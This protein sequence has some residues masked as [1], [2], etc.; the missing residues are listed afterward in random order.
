MHYIQKTKEKKYKIQNNI[1]EYLNFELKVD[2]LLLYEH[3][4]NCVLSSLSKIYCNIITS[5]LS[6]LWIKCPLTIFY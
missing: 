5:I 1:F 2:T 4:E 6:L 3:P